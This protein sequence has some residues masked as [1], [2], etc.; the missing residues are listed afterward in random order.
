MLLFS[1]SISISVFM[2]RSVFL[3]A[4]HIYTVAMEHYLF[5]SVLLTVKWKQLYSR[6]C[7]TNGKHVPGPG[8]FFCLW[9]LHTMMRLT[10]SVVLVYNRFK[11]EKDREQS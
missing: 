8:F 11:K 1:I 5:I 7:I 4:V 10:R 9:A 2:S 3:S 6:E